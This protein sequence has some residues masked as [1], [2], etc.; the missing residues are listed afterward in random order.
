MGVLE[1]KAEWEVLGTEVRVE[2][3]VLEATEAQGEAVEVAP[4]VFLEDRPLGSLRGILLVK[5][6]A[7]GQSRSQAG[8]SRR[9]RRWPSS[10][11]T[12]APRTT[13]ERRGAA[14]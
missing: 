4:V 13:E 9:R 11:A 2:Q 5:A 3:E 8:F 6:E 14:M 12:T 7:V 1:A 10:T